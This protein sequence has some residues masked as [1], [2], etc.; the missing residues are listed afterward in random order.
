MNRKDEIEARLAAI[1]DELEKPDA[2]IDALT[3][4]VRRLK[5]ELQQ[6][7]AA[8]E[9]RKKLRED[10][11]S[12]L[13]AVIRTFKPN[14]E[15][16]PFAINSEEYRTAWLKHMQGR[17]LSAVE[18]RAFTVANGAISQLVVNDIMTVVRDH[19]PLMERITMVYSASKITYY[20]EGTINPAKD[21]TENAT[22]TPD[23]D[24]LTPVE[25]TPAEITKM[26]QVS[27]A[28]RQMSVPAFNTWLTNMLGEAI[29]RFIN[30]KIINAI[31]TAATSAG[32]TIT[33]A[34]VQA[35]LGAVK[36]ENVA[37]ICNRKTLYTKLLPLQDNA[38]NNLVTFA[39][40]YGSARL[41]GYDILVDDNVA[42]NTVLAGDMSKVIG[43]MGE[44]INVR[45]GY[46]I[47]TNS[48]KYLGVA[49]FAV[50]VGVNAD[51][52]KITSE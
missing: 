8:A 40:T 35:L 17:D 2:N 33:A 45:E 6:I 47:D 1:R 23:A 7:N 22:I 27:D 13:G 51:F 14:G 49:V 46:D 19:A 37:V 43:A 11:S 21:H 15:D 48:Y 39:G 9:K 25:L 3:E 32:S 20:V 44:N 18:Q 12:G 24:T 10:V 38:A 5:N 30:S 26:V 28:A 34:D 36:G 52:A 29:A 4:E 16:M 41:Y 31:S 50:A 42:E